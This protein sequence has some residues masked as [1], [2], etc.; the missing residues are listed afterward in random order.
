MIL[1]VSR[2]TDIP[3]FY[4]EWFMN[5]IHE[6]Y[7]LTRNPMNYHQVSRI[8]ITPDVVDFIVFW[9]KNPQPLLPYL[10]EIDRNYPFYFQFTLNPYGQDLEPNLPS[11]EDRIETF[12]CISERFGK[13]RVIWRYDPIILS[14]KYDLLWHKQRFERLADVLAP[15][16]NTCVFSFVDIYD[17]NKGNLTTAN[18]MPI[19]IGQEDSLAR[20]FSLIASSHQLNLKTCA[21]DIN[22]EHFSIEHSCCIDAALME[23]IIGLKL[24]AKKDSAQRSQCHCAESI[25]IGQYNTCIHGCKYCYA[26]YSMIN[27]GNNYAKHDPK[28]PLLVGSLEIDD[29]VNDRKVKSLKQNQFSL[30]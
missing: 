10:D 5:R 14:E 24:S 2:R 12:R 20:E 21:E 26:N 8:P 17:K 19:S 3:A 18:Y 11:Q 30:F 7:V 9:S 15:Y 13:A 29:K 25:D 4:T 6:K 28:S 1:S 27:A 22:L 23:Q 16:T